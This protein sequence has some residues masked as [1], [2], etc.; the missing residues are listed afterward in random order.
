MIRLGRKC[1]GK[2][3]IVMPDPARI[4][5]R[6]QQMNRSAEWAASRAEISASSIYKMLGG[7]PVS[8]LL[9]KAVAAVLRVR[10]SQILKSEETVG[11]EAA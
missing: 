11:V 2:V 10:V 9:A 6:L 5:E 8:K 1:M 7:R 4:R 3:E